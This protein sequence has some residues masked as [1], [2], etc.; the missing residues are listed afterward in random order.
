[1]KVFGR[2]AA[3]GERISHRRTRMLDGVRVI[4]VADEQAEYAAS[5]SRPGADVSRSSRRRQHD[6]RDRPF[7]E[8]QP[9]RSARCS[10][11]ITTGA[12]VDR[13]RPWRPQQRESVMASSVALTCCC[14]QS[15]A[16]PG[17]A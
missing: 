1:V 8:D 5:C 13:G 17:C 2:A 10:S 6:T 14:S 11:G 9:I 16:A 15:E 12:S 7:Y 3:D 4:E